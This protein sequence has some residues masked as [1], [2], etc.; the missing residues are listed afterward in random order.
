LAFSKKVVV[1]ITERN[2]SHVCYFWIA[3]GGLP[4]LSTGI[5]IMSPKTVYYFLQLLSFL[6]LTQNE[7][8]EMT[9]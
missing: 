3:F 7:K 2:A 4:N 8:A 9:T 5:F 6:H 1:Y